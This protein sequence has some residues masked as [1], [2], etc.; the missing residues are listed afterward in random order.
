MGTDCEKHPSRIGYDGA[1]LSTMPTHDTI[2]D[3]LERLE[4][5][6][7]KIQE[8]HESKPA[9]QHSWN[10]MILIG[11]VLVFAGISSGY[12][13]SQ[14]DQK[15]SDRYLIQNLSGDILETSF[16]W[17]M[18][19]NEELHVHILSSET[20]S[21]QKLKAIQD[22]ILSDET[23]SVD[24]SM[25]HKGPS[26]TEST[27]YFGW[28]KAAESRNS[29]TVKPIPVKFHIHQVNNENGQILIK[30]TNEIS[31]DGITAYTNSIIDKNSKQ[32][33]KSTITIYGFDDLTPHEITTIIRH[34][35]GHALGL[36]HS[37]APE[38]LMY[39]LISTMYPYISECDLD[40]L[41]NLYDGKRQSTITCEK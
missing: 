35:F 6:S 34:E 16:A 41:T 23:I 1:T 25:L 29:N 11:M 3:R 33:L 38:D 39:P 21:S 10:K 14:E 7:C 8:N 22:A 27:Y 24:D 4:A 19:E 40:A 36:G 5:I 18:P 2:I 9:K 28:K 17:N 32:I 31:P 30:P 15:F 20:I 12:L 37:S 13:M 26:G